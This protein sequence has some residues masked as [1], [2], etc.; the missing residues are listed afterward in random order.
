MS[1][2]SPVL[3][4]NADTREPLLRVK[5]L[6]KHYPI[7][8]GVLK[9]EVGRVRAVDG[10]TFDV[11]PGE[12]LGLV[13][14]SG[15]GKST[16]AT[17]LLRIEEP[18]AGEVIF[19][20]DNILDY[21][22]EEIRAFRRR[23]QMIF[24]DPTSSFDP[25][26]T[27]GQ[28]VAE[29]LVIHGY[30][31]ETRRRR[32]VEDLLERVGLS[33]TDI[34]RYP[35]E[36]S[37]G[38]K[39]RIALARAMV[40]NPSLIVADEPTSALDVSIQSD[41][42]SL[43]NDLQDSYNLSIVFISHDMGVIR[44]VCDRIA[45]MYLGEIVEVGPTEQ[46]FNEPAHP[47]TRSLLS[48]IPQPDPRER[49]GRTQL[50]GEMPDPSNPPSGCRFHTRC[51]EVIQPETYDF[52][53]EHYQSLMYF[54]SHLREDDVDLEAA[55]EFAVAEYGVDPGAVSEDD[56]KRAIRDEYDLP[57]TLR[58]PDADAV[59]DAVFD[60]LL[61]EDVGA[62][63]ELLA[64][65]FESVC[66]RRD[67]THLC[68]GD[69]TI[70]PDEWR[71]VLALHEAAADGSIDVALE[72]QNDDNA[73]DAVRSV[74]GIDEPLSDPSVEEIVTRAVDA[75]CGGR[76]EEAATILYDAF[77]PAHTS[78]CHLNDDAV[79]PGTAVDGEERVS[80]SE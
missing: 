54:R 24:Q 57:D 46:V 20:G 34:D 75:I 76:H 22:G 35:H 31:N 51:P 64:D 9:R 58:D 23:A 6:K 17:S 80:R 7:T 1:E 13:G 68:A 55:E 3:D 12:T 8:E 59:L 14:E 63:R 37:G 5:N 43:M 45:V 69:V 33:A 40:V 38:Q 2:S 42:L 73:R 49:G 71:G 74:V 39:Q 11:R 21:N 66:E 29:P 52:D 47:Y 65:E 50:K 10:I 79:R 67:P 41:I 32:I 72:G 60:H 61:A 30:G 15:C 19:D 70:R 27:I 28:S 78:A 56:V 25:R 62:A 44:E 48:A 4:R 26:M 18:T 77:A 53:Q 36:F 16:A